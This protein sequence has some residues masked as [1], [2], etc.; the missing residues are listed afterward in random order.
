MASALVVQDDIEKGT[1]HTHSAVVVNETQF[2]ELVHVSEASTASSKRNLL[3]LPVSGEPAGRYNTPGVADS[4]GSP[5]LPE[6]N[7]SKCMKEHGS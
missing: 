2:A 4:H 5:A 3:L 1:V 6:G 7:G